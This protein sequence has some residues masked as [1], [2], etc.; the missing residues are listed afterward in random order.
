MILDYVNTMN[1]LS[2]SLSLLLSDDREDC[3]QSGHFFIVPRFVHSIHQHHIDI[4][5]TIGGGGEGGRSG[6]IHSAHDSIQLNNYSIIV[7]R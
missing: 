7:N 1:S 6:T 2:L 3:S 5:T 4:D